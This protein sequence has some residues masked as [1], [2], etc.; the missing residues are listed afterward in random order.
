MVA[1]QKHQQTCTKCGSVQ[2]LEQDKDVLDTWFQFS[3]MA[4]LNT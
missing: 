3:I 1:R 4:F 2:I